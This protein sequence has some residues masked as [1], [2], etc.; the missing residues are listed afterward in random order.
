MKAFVVHRLPAIA[1]AACLALLAGCGSGSG[2]PA[3]SGG[4]QDPPDEPPPTQF[5]IHG[6]V[7]AYESGMI[8]DA[9]VD[10]WVQT[11]GFG[12]AYSLAGGPLQSDG[13]GQFEAAV[14]R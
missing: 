10:L 14:P 7:F 13:L 8:D 9:Q 5:A 3:G 11:A 1:E 4:S 6:E 2:S 12:Y